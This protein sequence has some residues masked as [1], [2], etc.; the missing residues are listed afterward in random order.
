MVATDAAKR[1][2][3]V[4]HCA[5]T[6]QS[7][8]EGIDDRR[9]HVQRFDLSPNLANERDP[10]IVDLTIIAEKV[11][12]WCEFSDISL[13]GANPSLDG[14]HAEQIEGIVGSHGELIDE[15]RAC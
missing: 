11:K 14:T 1:N 15:E 12:P 2:R 10:V 4:G 13:P 8:K 3:L 5:H 9:C 7:A 6:T